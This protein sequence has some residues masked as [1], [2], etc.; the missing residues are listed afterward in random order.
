MA[1]DGAMNAALYAVAVLA[2]HDPAL[3]ARLEDFRQKQAE[4]VLQTEL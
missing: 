1:I 3:A 4:K 2:L